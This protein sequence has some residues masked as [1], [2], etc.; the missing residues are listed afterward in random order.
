MSDET[1]KTR[2][3][4]GEFLTA[5]Q[6]AEVLQVSE[7]TVRKLAREGR[8]PAVRLTPRLTRYNLQSVLRALDGGAPKARARRG[9]APAADDE[10]QLPFEDAV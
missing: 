9:Q 3:G 6:I 5:R 1:E 10:L 4:R 7:S 8:I 2:N